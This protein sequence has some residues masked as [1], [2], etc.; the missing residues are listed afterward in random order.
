MSSVY[1]RL[2]CFRL[3]MIIIV[4][5]LDAQGAIDRGQMQWRQSG[6]EGHLA[7]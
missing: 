2:W 3:V 7:N 4:D 1:V 6:L 5:D